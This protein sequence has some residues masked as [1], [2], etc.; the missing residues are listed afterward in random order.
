ML[1]QIASSEEL[2]AVSGRVVAGS[3]YDHLALWV[4]NLV[5]VEEAVIGENRERLPGTGIAEL[6][7]DAVL[8][9]AKDGQVGI[10]R[11]R[12]ERRANG[13]FE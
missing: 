10:E 9:C 6:G 8:R 2:T 3:E 4:V 1:V 13:R 7:R 11:T 5:V 12:I